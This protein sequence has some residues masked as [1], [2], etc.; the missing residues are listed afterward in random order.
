MI[1]TIILLSGALVAIE[2]GA[3]ETLDWE[4]YGDLERQEI[5][6]YKHNRKNQ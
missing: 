3:W 5:A 2:K 1:G 6:E 4:A